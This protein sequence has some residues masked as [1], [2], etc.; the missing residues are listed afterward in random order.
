MIIRMATITHTRT[1]MGTITGTAMAMRMT[2]AMTMV[3]TTLTIIPMI[4]AIRTT[5]IT[6][7]IR[8]QTIRMGRVRWKRRRAEHE[9]LGPDP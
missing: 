2:T 6:I 8:M 7:P 5:I 9:C 3:T 1:G 4:R